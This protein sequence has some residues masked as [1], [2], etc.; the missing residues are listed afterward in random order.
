MSIQITKIKGI[1]IRLHF[2]LIV[3]FFLI[4]WT[5][6]ASLMPEIHPGLTRVQYWI[7][8]ILG[9]II[10]FTSIL[11]HELAHSIVAS[12]YGLK[13][14]QIIL[15]I[16]GGVSD[17]EEGD[18]SKD[19][20]KE[21]KIAI[22]GPITSFV[23]AGL[24]GL[25]WWVLTSVATITTIANINNYATTIV[26]AEAILQYG[27]TINTMLGGFNLIPAFP[28]DGGRILRSALLRWKKDYD[29]STKIAVRFGT[30]ISYV[31]MAVG[32]IIILSGSFIGGIWL[33]FIGWFLN[34]GAQSY[35]ERHQKSSALSGVHLRDIM[36]IRFVSV[37]PDITVNELLHNY[38][39]VYRKSEFPVVVRE[40]GDYDTGYYYRLLGAVTTKQALKIPEH[41]KD[42][43][44]V[45]EIM[46]SKDELIVM[47]S[48]RLADDALK[49]MLR[50]NKNMVFI[51]E[52]EGNVVQKEELEPKQQRGQ[53]LVGLISKTDILNVARQREEFDK[54]VEKLSVSGSSSSNN[55][56]ITGSSNFG[57]GISTSSYPFS[58]T[59]SYPSSI[60]NNKNDK[61]NIMSRWR[62]VFFVFGMIVFI[63]A[64]F[65]GA[66]FV[67]I[68]TSQADFI[69]S[70][71]QEQIR[72]VNQYGIFANNVRVALGMFVPGLGIALGTFSAFSTGLVFNAFS[73][74]SP[75]LPNISPLIV[76]LTPFGILEIIAYGIA[77]SRSGI[78]S[79]QLIKDRNKRNSWRKYVIPTI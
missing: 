54:A 71:F 17:I 43:I 57:K 48:N 35:L 56:A 50:E 67:Q 66:K 53:K 61:F 12:R 38:F 30:A 76:F 45:Q 8:G 29:Q 6:S 37:E 40:G 16:F 78:L 25:S 21:F 63:M 18:S 44:K 33:L 20:H 28:L 13:V 34:S 68:N 7:I 27:A 42:I 4:V 19:F 10:S 39:N 26:I 22:A 5:L 47:K 11:L 14:R 55:Q 77:I 79:Y 32:F 62:F 59:H 75:A 72:G 24:L 73:T 31:F 49:R 70:H 2:T 15:F 74:F 51:Y 41:S 58:E 65:V 23:I 9:A 1:P 60:H 46:V 69:R 64:Y 36:N 52:E 3:I